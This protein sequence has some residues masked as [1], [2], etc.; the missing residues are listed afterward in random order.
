MSARDRLVSVGS[1]GRKIAPRPRTWPKGESGMQRIDPYAFYDLGMRIHAIEKI[2]KD[3]I[4][5][6]VWL[7][8]WHARMALDSVLNNQI[9]ALDICRPACNKLRASINAIIPE[10]LTKIA[11]EKFDEK[12]DEWLVYILGGNLKEFETIFAAEL[13]AADVYFVSQKEAYD[14]SD[15]IEVAEKIFPEEIRKTFTAQT[16]QDVRQAGRCLAFNLATAAGFHI[17]RALENITLEAAQKIPGA[18]LV[19]H[20]FHEYIRVL[21]KA[22]VDK[23][24][25]DE[26]DRLRDKYR[27][28]LMHPE[29][30]LSDIEI[31]IL[32]SDVKN[33]MI[34][35]HQDIYRVMALAVM[36]VLAQIAAV[37]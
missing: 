15:L 29:I 22:G 37:P 35:L 13:Q 9:I 19:K 33:V 1:G 5:R 4:L 23:D 11:A 36:P 17:T 26:L 16:V 27:N 20:D 28:Q 32:V 12:L 14:T 21:E 10:D 25:I 3:Q 30:F 6:E 31:S 24:V 8:L 18:K 2:N 34:K 7:A